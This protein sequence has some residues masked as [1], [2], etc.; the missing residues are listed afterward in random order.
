MQTAECNA[1][2]TADQIVILA[3]DD[4]DG[5][6]KITTLILEADGYF[7]L[8]GH[9]CEEALTTFESFP[10]TIHAVVSDIKMPKLNGLDLR[11]RIIK[12]HPNTKVLL[13]SGQP[14]FEIMDIPFLRKSL[15][16][17]N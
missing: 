15:A 9:D 8:T 13:M 11:S 14:G 1:T 3:V 2:P 12:E 5:V 6:L 7:V 16:H 17:R 10:G 4:G